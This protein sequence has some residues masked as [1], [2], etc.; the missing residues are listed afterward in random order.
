MSKTRI[1]VDGSVWAGTGY[2]AFAEAC[3]VHKGVN[4]L[5]RNLHDGRIEIF[6]DGPAEAVYP[7]IEE[8]RRWDI[9]VCKNSIKRIN[10]YAEGRRG[11]TPAWKDYNGFDIDYGNMTQYEQELINGREWFVLG[12]MMLR[13]E[14]S[15]MR[16]D[17]RKIRCPAD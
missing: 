16:E 9:G 5:V 13:D 1:V 15:G 11:Y 12:L 8:L 10:V 2:R 3:A 14:F 17:L 4:G 7:L 6:Y